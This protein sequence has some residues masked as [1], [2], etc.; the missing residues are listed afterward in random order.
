M[1][2]INNLLVVKYY[3][4]LKINYWDIVPYYNSNTFPYKQT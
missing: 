3:Y 2:T 4:F 1:Q